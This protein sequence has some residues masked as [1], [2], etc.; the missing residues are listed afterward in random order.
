AAVV[1]A[2]AA[3]HAQALLEKEQLLCAER[4]LRTSQDLL[5]QGE[6]FNHAGSMRYLV[7]EDLMFCSDELCRI[8]GLPPGRNCITYDEF[9]SI[10]HPDDRQ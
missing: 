10:M 7:R 8:Y 4:E 2:N 3:D 9:A 1:L 6:R 5:K